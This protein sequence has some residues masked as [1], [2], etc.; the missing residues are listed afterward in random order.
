M[1]RLLNNG[2]IVSGLFNYTVST[3]GLEYLKRYTDQLPIDGLGS[4]TGKFNRPY[5]LLFNL[6]NGS[7]N[8]TA[9]NEMCTEGMNWTDLQ[10]LRL[11]LVERLRIV[12]PFL[13]SSACPLFLVP[14]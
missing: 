10:A 14:N 5:F 9:C 3:A 1:S 2:S 12:E 6:R 4:T 11:Y 7:V 8:Q 13:H